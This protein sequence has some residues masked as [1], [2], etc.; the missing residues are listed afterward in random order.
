[1]IALAAQPAEKSSFEQLGTQGASVVRVNDPFSGANLSPSSATLFSP[2][3]HTPIRAVMKE[4]SA[5]PVVRIDLESDPVANG[6][7]KSLARPG[8]NLT[9]LFLDIPELGG[10]QIELLKKV[11]P[12]ATYLAVLW[13]A[14]IGDLQFRATEIAAAPSGTRLVSLP[15]RSAGQIKD[16]VGGAAHD[17]VDGES[18]PD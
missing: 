17:R 1:V 18:G 2:Q 10:K 9:G 12:R 4:T 5:I 16:A 14:T 3:L 8:G 15:I 11:V 13:D 6:W 7:I